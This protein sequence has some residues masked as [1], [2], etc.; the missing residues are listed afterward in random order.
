MHDVCFVRDAAGHCLTCSD[1][2]MPV[3]VTTVDP[4]TMFA[5]VLVD[6]IPT[7]IDISLIDPVVPGDTILVH[8][9]TALARL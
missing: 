8:G 9:G 2:A 1:E 5:V 3:V 6:D 4:T 7:E